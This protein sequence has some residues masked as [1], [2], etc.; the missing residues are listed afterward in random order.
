MKEE[1]EMPCVVK[2]NKIVCY[3]LPKGSKIQIKTK[4]DGKLYWSTLEKV[5]YEA[6]PDMASIEL[7]QNGQDS[8]KYKKFG[9]ELVG[10]VEEVLSREL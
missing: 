6:L 5:L 4:N 8:K 9:T 7:F 1:I 10:T 2:K 3:R